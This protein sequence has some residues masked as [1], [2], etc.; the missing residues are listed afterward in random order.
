MSFPPVLE[1]LDLLLKG[2]DKCVQADELERK[3]TRSLKTGKPLR[4]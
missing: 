3:L 4:N 1:Q 2:I